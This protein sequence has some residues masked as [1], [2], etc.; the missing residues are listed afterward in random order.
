MANVNEETSKQLTNIT[1]IFNENF[2]E[3]DE[4]IHHLE[5]RYQTLVAEKLKLNRKNNSY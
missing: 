4:K 1:E 2:V 5:K 3:L